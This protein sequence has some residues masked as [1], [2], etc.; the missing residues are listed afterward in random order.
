[1][2]DVIFVT[3]LISCPSNALCR[4]AATTSLALECAGQAVKGKQ[5]QLKSHGNVNQPNVAH[6][7]FAAEMD[8][9]YEQNVIGVHEGESLLNATWH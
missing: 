7:I 6:A 1:M 2:C 8:I 5:N 3:P 4:S 9:L